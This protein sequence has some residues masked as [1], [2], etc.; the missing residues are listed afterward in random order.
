[1][2][3]L[4]RIFFILITAFTN[5]SYAAKPGDMAPEIASQLM[6]GG[7]VSLQALRGNVVLVNFFASWCP[8]CRKELPELNKLYQQ[9]SAQNLH[10]LGINLDQDRANA[11]RM[12]KEFSL[13]FP[14]VFDPNKNIIKAYKGK[15]MPVSYIINRKG[16]IQ[17][18][19][20]GYAEKKLPAI[21]QAVQR[22]LAQ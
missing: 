19:I 4:G 3:M 21:K 1:M 22:A 9:E 14:V 2:S 7:E 13:S 18:V 6:D 5:L 15:T 20:Y 11:E 12:I 10:V 8:P 16:R 17:H